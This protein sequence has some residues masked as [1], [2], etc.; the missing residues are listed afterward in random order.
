MKLIR[1]LLKLIG[2]IAMV[3]ASILLVTPLMQ[4][5]SDKLYKAHELKEEINFDDLGP[6]VVRKSGQEEK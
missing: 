6:K 2:I 5:L 1:A 4:K 3:A